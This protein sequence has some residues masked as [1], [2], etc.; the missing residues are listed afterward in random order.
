MTLPATIYSAPI[1]VPGLL[2]ATSNA[3]VRQQVSRLVE[4]RRWPMIEACGGADALEKLE[5]SEC[6]LLL[7]DE[8]LPDL[9]AEDLASLIGERFPG[10]DVLMLDADTGQPAKRGGLKTEAA[11]EVMR[12][13]L[14]QPEESAEAAPQQ[15]IDTLPNMVGRS[16]AM[17]KVY[18]AARLVA[19]RDTSVLLVGESGTGKELIAKAVHQLSSRADKP[20]MTINCAAIPETLL[21]SELFGYERGAFTGAAQSRIGRIH[22]AQG[23]TLFLDEIGEMPLGLQPKILRFLEQGEVQRLGSSDVFRVDVRLIAATNCDLEKKVEEQQFRRDLLYRLGVFPI[24]MPRLKDR[25]GDLEQLARHFLRELAGAKAEFSAAAIRMLLAHD[26]P[27]NVRELRHVI[28]RATILAD[29]APRIA[30]EHI[31]VKMWGGA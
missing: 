1:D 24:A 19:P 26:W 13:L 27:G 18:R 12:C 23:G 2:L 21:E 25:S 16:E 8:R 4:Q 17:Q 10:V 28:E 22:A 20:M 30:P 6:R 11:Y 29:G 31:V 9:Q 5:A 14:S 15:R 7:M 3:A